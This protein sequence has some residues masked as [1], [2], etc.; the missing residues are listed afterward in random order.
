MAELPDFTRRQYE[1]AAHIRDPESQPR[2]ADVDER[3]MAAYRELFFNNIEDFLGN[4]FPVLSGILGKERWLKML[5]D[6]YAR[7]RAM[8]PLFSEFPGEFLR[9]LNETRMPQPDD[10]P[11]MEELAHYEWMEL[12]VAQADT[13]I[14]W[15]AIDANGD[16]L[17][18]IPVV[19]PLAWVLGYEYPVHR[20]G[21]AYHPDAPPA[22][23]TWLIVHRDADDEVRFIEINS[24]T[25]RLLQ[26]LGEGKRLTGRRV[27]EQLARELGHPEPAAVLEHGRTILADLHARQIVPGTRRSP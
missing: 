3:R 4:A 20:I 8:T 18:G 7:H 25:A 23:C 1:F 9:Y 15:N 19:S 13:T 12:V 6:F 14:D 24:V 21:P 11:F 16:P 26:L 10:P 2:P 17:D 5:R 22:E 27:L